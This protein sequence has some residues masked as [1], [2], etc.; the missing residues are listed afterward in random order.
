L[1]ELGDQA[2][3]LCDVLAHPINVSYE[4]RGE[5]LVAVNGVAVRNMQHL[6]KLLDPSK[7]EGVETLELDFGFSFED[8]RAERRQFVVFET[9]EVLVTTKEILKQNKIPM[10]CSAEL[11][12]SLEAQEEE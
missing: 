1:E 6:V 8:R 5:R 11:L 9:N 4:F 10:W 7:L 12:S 3:V 2:I